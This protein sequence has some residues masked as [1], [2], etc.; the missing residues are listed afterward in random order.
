ML[1]EKYGKVIFPL[2][3][4]CYSILSFRVHARSRLHVTRALTGQN[5]PNQESEKRSTALKHAMKPL[6]CQ[7][8]SVSNAHSF[9]I[10][11]FLLHNAWFLRVFAHLDFLVSSF[12]ASFTERL[13]AAQ[14]SISAKSTDDQYAARVLTD[15]QS[16]YEYNW[17]RYLNYEQSWVNLFSC[18]CEIFAKHEG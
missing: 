8:S 14:Q 1:N 10:S 5:V 3:S 16:L 11:I 2:G 18:P 7:W 6:H 12:H 4:L 13:W 17:N 15:N 9:Q